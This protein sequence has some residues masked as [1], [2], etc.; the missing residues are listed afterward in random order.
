MQQQGPGLGTCTPSE[1]ITKLGTI[2]RHRQQHTLA[3]LPHGYAS[4]S[5]SA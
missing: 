2:M 1:K 5:S 4:S 3:T